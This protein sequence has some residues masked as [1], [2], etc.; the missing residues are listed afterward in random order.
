MA[1]R[2][3]ALIYDDRA[4]PETTGV[5]CLVR[6]GGWLRSSIFSLMSWNGFRARGLIC[7]LNID[8]G[9]PYHLPQ[10]CGLV[11][12]GPSIRTSISSR[13][14]I[15]RLGSTSSSRPSAMGRK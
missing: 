10:T 3:V 12:G 5:Y 6:C 4:R 13:A 11:P 2:R 9:F 1:I 8:D 15:K 7:Y 14:L